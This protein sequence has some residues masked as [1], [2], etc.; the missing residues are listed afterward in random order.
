MLSIMELLVQEIIWNPSSLQDRT[1]ISL[2]QKGDQVAF[3]ALVRKYQHHLSGLVRRHAGRTTDGEDLLQRLICKVYFSLKSFDIDRPFYPWL[4]RVAVN[5]C[6][7]ER[8]RLRRKARTFV[9]LEPERIGATRARLGHAIDSC[10]AARKQEMNDMIRTVIG[11]LPEQYQEVI[12]LYHLKQISYAEIGAML[13][14]TPRAARIRAFRAR[15]ALRRLLQKASSEE[16]RC[17]ASQTAF[18]RLD[19]CCRQNLIKSSR[20]DRINGGI[21]ESTLTYQ[22]T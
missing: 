20:S 11:M 9:E 19:A 4:R 3:E 2:S 21:K 22:G 5:L 13:N 18:Q 10:S 15:D 1:L 7:D 12:N 14:C 6:L 17:P 8:R 16:E